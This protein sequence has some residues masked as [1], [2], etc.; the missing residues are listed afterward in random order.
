D[1]P[2]LVEAGPEA[3]AVEDLVLTEY[4]SPPQ[5]T[6]EITVVTNLDADSTSNTAVLSNA[7]AYEVGES[8]ALSTGSYEYQTTITVY[9]SLGSPHDVS[10][11]YDKKSETEW[12]YVIV[13]NP[14]ED[15]RNLVQD[16]SSQGLLARGTIEFSES[17][18]QI[19]HMTMEEFTGRVGNV[20]TSGINTAENVHFQIED[21]QSMPVDGYGIGMEYNGEQWVLNESELPEGYE[22]AEIVYSDEQTVYLVM[23]A[24]DPANTEPDL[25][26]KL[27][28][29]AMAGDT[30][31][32]DINDPEDTHVQ[33]VQNPDYQG[34]AANNT[35][36]EINN[37]NTMTRDAQGC[38]IVWNP[39]TEEWQWSNPEEAADAGT[40]VTSDKSVDIQD[41]SAMTMSSEDVTLRYDGATGQWY[42]NQPLKTEDFTGTTDTMAPDNSPELAVVDSGTQGAMPTAPTTLTWDGTQWTS[43]N[44]GVVIDPVASN[45]NQVVFTTD[46]ATVQYSFDQELTGA[47]AGQAVSFSIE[48]SPPRE[49]PDAVVTDPGT[50]SA[51][52]DF[53]G[54]G[55]TDLAIDPGTIPAD[56]DTMVF[57][58]DPDV[59][60]KEY[61]D[62]TL[63]GDETRAVIDL[64]GSGNEN[65]NEDLVF[66]F[67]DPLKSGSDTHPGNDNSVITFDIEGSSAWREVPVEEAEETGHYQFTADFL[68]GEYGST[69]TDISFDIGTEYDGNN[70]VNDSLST[71]QYARASS[72]TYQDSDGYPPGD[73]MDVEVSS[74]G[75]VTGSYSNGQQIPLFRV[76]L[77]DFSNEDGLHSEG[78]NLYSSTNESGPAITNKPGENGLGM[79]APYTLEMSNV[80][81]SEEFVDMI[82]LQRAF[83]AN[84]KIISTVDEM[85]STVIQMKR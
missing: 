67:D 27:D 6:E 58:V 71:T 3:P 45:G 22:N 42:F 33:D 56:G 8:T 28:Q 60:P 43:D 29:P 76:A 85:M 20:Q 23:D 53:D 65:D 77:A 44:P 80:D 47:E 21:S 61:P 35:S 69:E 66:T 73:L 79:I 31:T 11:M 1:E 68:G 74:D 9:D 2:Q 81:I 59:P 36:I 10:I 13:S 57:S 39:A 63:K 14:E 70:F 82:A 55:S 12:E 4:T 18:G 50:G 17:S 32:F 5:E 30:I 25:K 16:T 46:G 48:P 24:S 19:T 51:G 84:A 7:Y 37:P 64:D 38:S 49:Y 26:I 83:E 78:G 52:V 75:V 15:Q 34:D 72:T 54:N 40:L 62:A 41:P